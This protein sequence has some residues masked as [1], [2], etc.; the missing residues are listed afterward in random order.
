MMQLPRV[1]YIF[2]WFAH[3]QR[4]RVVAYG[5]D[6]AKYLYR[7]HA[8]KKQTQNAEKEAHSI[9]REEPRISV[10]TRGLE[11]ADILPGE[12]PLV[13][14]HGSCTLLGASDDECAG[15]PPRF[16]ATSRLK[17]TRL[18]RPVCGFG[19]GDGLAAGSA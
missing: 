17:R 1:L 16:T 4:F 19:G 14:F 10:P 3:S 15:R 6:N 7:Q 8:R 11:L 13:P 18:L 2:R 12:A 9:I 5:H